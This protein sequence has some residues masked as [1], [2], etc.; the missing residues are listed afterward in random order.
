MPGP[1]AGGTDGTV[2]GW[3]KM[4]DTTCNIGGGSLQEMIAG[5]K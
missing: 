5:I 1:R 2:A 4:Q 3:S